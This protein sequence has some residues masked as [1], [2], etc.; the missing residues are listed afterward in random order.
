MLDQAAGRARARG[1]LPEGEGREEGARMLSR[2]R[3]ALAR[4]GR[5]SLG[6]RRDGCTRAR[7][8]RTSGVSGRGLHDRAQSSAAS[9]RRG[10]EGA[11]WGSGEDERRRAGF[12]ASARVE[13]QGASWEIHGRWS[14]GGGGRGS[15]VLVC[16][17]TR[18]PAKRLAHSPTSTSL[19]GSLV[20]AAPSLSPRLVPPPPSSL[21]PLALSI[22]TSRAKQPPSQP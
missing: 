19:S 4:V 2:W 5:V 9:E 14:R 17:L 10:G 20:K 3:G 1:E 22:T 8:R 16:I 6:E 11:L 18:S 13:R 12:R 21:L 15:L 7:R